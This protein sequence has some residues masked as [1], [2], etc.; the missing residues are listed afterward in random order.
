MARDALYAAAV[1]CGGDHDLT[2]QKALTD[3]PYPSSTLCH[4]VPIAFEQATSLAIV[5]VW[6]NL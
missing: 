3:E 4:R 2:A 5:I 1:P 6:I